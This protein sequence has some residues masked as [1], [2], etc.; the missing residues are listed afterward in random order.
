MDIKMDDVVVLEREPCW[1]CKGHGY[2]YFENDTCPT[3]NGT[4]IEKVRITV[5][6]LIEKFWFSKEKENG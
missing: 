6:D 4:G 5:K 3:C 2:G 1:S